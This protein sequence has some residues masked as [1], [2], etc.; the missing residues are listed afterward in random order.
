M[1]ELPQGQTITLDDGSTVKVVKM[2]GEGGQGTVYNV[3]DASGNNYALK[4]YTAESIIN[5]DAFYNNLR[6][7]IKEG[8]PTDAFLWPLKATRKQLGSYGYI[9]KLR[10]NGFNELGDFFAV[11][12]HPEARFRNFS[13]QISAAIHICNGFRTLHI[14][15]YSYQDLNE[16]NFFVNPTTGDVLICDND[17]VVANGRNLGVS[18]KVR[19]M[20]PEVVNG[21][22]PD[23]QSD[24][25][26]LAIILYRL[27]MIDHPFE[28][29]K[30]LVPC[31]TP[32]KERELFGKG[33]VFCQ[34]TQNPANR[35]DPEQ[36]PNSIAFWPFIPQSLK[37]MFQR[38]LSKESLL[39][40]GKRVRDKEWKE[41]F[42]KLR[43]DLV[44]C[45]A[46]PRE[47]KDHD[48]MTDGDAST[49]ILCK[50][51][52][53]TTCLLKFKED[54]TIYRFFRHKH[55]YLGESMNP[56][57]YGLTRKKQDG[58]TTEIA[59]RNDS[60]DT[61]TVV[62]ASK[63]MR[64]LAPGELMPLRT[65]MLITFNNAHSCEVVIP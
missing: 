8:A 25:L 35:P 9:M 63:K 43:R 6:L 24:C 39:N 60:R 17:N 52:I 58:Q 45:P 26:S 19:Y 10:P 12:R 4:W 44:V 28:G 49:C 47:K 61:W 36:H 31:L 22:R 42:L 40:P 5:N 13:N 59:L 56:V 50:K 29:V 14:H 3:K 32:E 11:D 64:K 33:A 23:I 15:G 57:G 7:N 18:G 51:T 65:G 54:G 27:F 21:Q 41:L 62:T 2:L 1:S 20:A 48:F 37:A 34:D 30:T 16:G 53:K 55:L 46:P 38:A